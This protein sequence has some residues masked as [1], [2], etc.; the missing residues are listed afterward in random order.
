MKKLVILVLAFCICAAML[1]AQE[2]GDFTVGSRLGF[3]FGF[4][5]EGDD[6]KYIAPGAGMLDDSSLANFNLAFY[7]EYSLTDAMAL[8]TEFNFM[9]AQ[10]KKWSGYGT[11]VEVT[12]SSLDIPILFKYA[13]LKKP[14]V[15]G[16][17]G[18]PYLSFPIGKMKDKISVSGYSVSDESDTEGI[19]F[20][21]TLGAYAGFPLGP[22]RIVGDM[23]FIFDF[24]Q[25]QATYQNVT[26]KVLRRNGLV[27][28]AGYEFTF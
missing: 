14:L 9:I 5:S 8:Q 11:T 27:I 20:G 25:I 22:G 18:G 13:F 19:T 7:G 1:A 4:H 15:V 21:M 6:F 17:L 26:R 3:M 2:G 28:T 10:G 23:R 24:N 16:A 12:Y